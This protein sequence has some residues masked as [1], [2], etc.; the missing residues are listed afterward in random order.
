MEF[1]SYDGEK[2]HTTQGEAD[3]PEGSRWRICYHGLTIRL[4]L[5]LP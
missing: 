3:P 4:P 1:E 2:K 5:W